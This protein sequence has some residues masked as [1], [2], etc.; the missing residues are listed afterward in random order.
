MYFGGS[1][2]LRGWRGSWRRRGGSKFELEFANSSLQ[3]QK[4][5]VVFFGEIVELFAKL[6][7]P[8]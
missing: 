7:L 4:L 8:E 1:R 6:G 3:F 5:L 2:L